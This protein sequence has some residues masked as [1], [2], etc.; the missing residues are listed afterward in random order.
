MAANAMDVR[1][2]S[3]AVAARS[4]D[5]RQLTAFG[6]SAV[7]ATFDVP[8]VRSISCFRSALRKNSTLA[9]AG[10]WTSS[11]ALLAQAQEL[12]QLRNA[13]KFMREKP[14]RLAELD[15][16]A[17]R[18]SRP[19]K[20]PSP[21]DGGDKEGRNFKD[22]FRS[23]GSPPAASGRPRKAEFS[24]KQIEG[25]ASQARARNGQS[26]GKKRVPINTS[27]LA[28]GGTVQVNRDLSRNIRLS[29]YIARTGAASRRAA[30][31]LIEE[32]HVTVNGKQVKEQMLVNPTTVEVTVKGQKLMLRQRAI[33]VM[34]NKPKGYISTSNDPNDRKTVM[35]LVPFARRDGLVAVG[36]LDRDSTGLLLMT[37]DL[38]FVNLLTH[39]RYEHTKK[40]RAEISGVLSAPDA[41][42]LASGI[43]LDGEERKT[44]PCGISF[45][46][47]RKDGKE[48]STVLEVELK[49]GRRQQIRRMFEAV[50]RPVV[51]L[52]RFEF[53]GLELKQTKRGEYK[54][55][56]SSDIAFVQKQALRNEEKKKAQARKEQS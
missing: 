16:M 10:S 23:A 48:V 37:N 45:I 47:H 20:S 3:R 13:G 39:P 1:M 15:M 29:H 17:G 50:N 32:G 4:A 27:R 28:R 55:L 40:Y 53:A 54:V 46:E 9:Q 26:R 43:L 44:A 7:N 52:H 33:W 2:T 36:R 12:V 14:S 35:D 18:P 24:A 21:R 11:R 38:R 5:A 42:R 31:K 34:V 49:E 56:S 22:K 19:R 51:R 30:E 41:Y 8:G 25:M 6:C